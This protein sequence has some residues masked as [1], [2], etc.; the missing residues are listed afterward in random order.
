MKFILRCNEK[1]KFIDIPME[2]VSFCV[3]LLNVIDK[4][5]GQHIEMYKE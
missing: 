4:L 5:I 3:E 2:S 1:I